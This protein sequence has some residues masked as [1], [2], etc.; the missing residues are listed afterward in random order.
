MTVPTPLAKYFG[1]YFD[2]DLVDIENRDDVMRAAEHVSSSIAA[3]ES[4]AA[5]HEVIEAIEK[6]LPNLDL[7]TILEF[8]RISNSLWSGEDFYVDHL[9]DALKLIL[10]RAKEKLADYEKTGSWVRP[11]T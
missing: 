8:E 6:L 1:T 7:P 2:S 3:F 5:V 10:D 11:A 4:P 9:R